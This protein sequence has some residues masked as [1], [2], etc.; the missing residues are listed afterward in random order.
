MHILTIVHFDIYEHYRKWALQNK[1]LKSLFQNYN[2][3]HFSKHLEYESHT[4]S[5]KT[6]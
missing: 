1:N 4:I 6:K 5:L 3:T 2:L